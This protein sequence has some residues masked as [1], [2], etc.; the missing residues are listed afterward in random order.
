MK[1]SWRDFAADCACIDGGPH[2]SPRAFLAMTERS[3]FLAVLESDDPAERTVYLDQACAGDPALRSQVE[4]LLKAHQQT[5]PFMARPAAL[6]V[7]AEEP[8]CERPGTVIGP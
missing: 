1:K 5:G 8:V 4:Q 2:L 3:I 6:V 7:T